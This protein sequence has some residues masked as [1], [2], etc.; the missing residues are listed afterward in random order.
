VPWDSTWP[1]NV[2]L[3]TPVEE[4]EWAAK[5]IPAL[6]ERS[7]VIRFPSFESLL[8]EKSRRIS[9]CKCCDIGP[10]TLLAFRRR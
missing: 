5:Q 1:P 3:G 7:A 8:G 4:A 9:R 6:L 10:S 2:W